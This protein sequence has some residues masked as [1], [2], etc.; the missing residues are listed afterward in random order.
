MEKQ[1]ILTKEEVE[2]ILNLC[3]NIGNPDF[4]YGADELKFVFLKYKLRKALI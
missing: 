1:I 2:F 3:I 4:F